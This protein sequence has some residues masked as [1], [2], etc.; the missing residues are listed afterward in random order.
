MIELDSK[1]A[2]LLQTYP[3]LKDFLVQLNP[4]FALLNSGAA[5][6]TVG[7]IATVRM[8]ASVAGIEPEALLAAIAEEVGR[9]SGEAPTAGGPGP[10]ESTSGNRA[11]ALKEVIRSL[12]SGASLEEAR[13]KFASA[14][15][16]I[17]GA[18]IAGIEEELIREGLPVSE[19]QRL[20]DL[21][22][23]TFKPALDSNPELSAPPGHP[24]HTY[25]AENVKISELSRRLQAL[26]GPTSAHA[27]GGSLEHLQETERTLKELSGVEVHYARKENQLFPFLERHGVSGP[28]RVMWGVHDEIRGLLRASKKAAGGGD[29][30]ALRELAPKLCLALVEMVYKE[31]KILFPMALEVMTEEEWAEARR[32]EAEIGYPYGAPEAQWTTGRYSTDAPAASA[33]GTVD[34]KTGT[35]STEMVA[36]M[37]EHLPVEISL[38]DEN[39]TVVYYSDS[40]ERIFPRSPAVIGRKVQNCHPEKSLHMVN[41]ILDA[42]KAGERY[43][44]EFWINSS[45]RFLHLLYIA[46]RDGDGRYRGCLESTQDATGIRRLEGERRLLEWE[47]VE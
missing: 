26:I 27:P 37:L 33:P 34:L 40:K 43:R 17:G 35:L 46:I 32:G 25:A 42:F 3:F 14:V 36:L 15:A 6:A 18:E 47:C 13:G 16:G 24:V 22:V 4:K 9:R 19:I 31:E 38:V 44:A 2:T 11:E 39:D 28:S 21:H 23:G 1:I 8:A 29:L 5:R 12:H 30:N 7:K 10:M 41:A 45:G 20:C